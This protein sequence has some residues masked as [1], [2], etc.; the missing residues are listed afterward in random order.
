VAGANSNCTGSTNYVLTPI[1]AIIPIHDVRLRRGLLNV[2][3]NSGAEIWGW[4]RTYHYN[5]GGSERMM[6]RW[7]LYGMEYVSGIVSRSVG[8]LTLPQ[9]SWFPDGIVI[10]MSRTPIQLSEHI[11]IVF[12]L[13]TNQSLPRWPVEQCSD[14]WVFRSLPLS[15][16]FERRWQLPVLQCPNNRHR[17]ERTWT[18]VRLDC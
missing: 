5:V 12:R 4:R 13:N 3:N 10:L 17:K 15:V 1:N 14:H 11:E 9:K 2:D 7:E 18:Q 16:L 6:Y 8:A